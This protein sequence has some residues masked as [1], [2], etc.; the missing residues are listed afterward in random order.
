[1]PLHCLTFIACGA[2]SGFKAVAEQSDDEERIGFGRNVKARVPE[3]IAARVME[4]ELDRTTA[5]ARYGFLPE[6]IG[7][8]NRL[9]AFAPLD[10]ESL[11]AIL[12]DGVLA[13]Y[14]QE[15][16]QEGITLVLE[17]GVLDHL[18]GQALQRETGAR[19]LRA[20]MARSLEDAAY[21]HFGQSGQRTVSLR[22]HGDA[23]VADG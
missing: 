12:V 19:G 9:V 17:E 7:R 23:V 18:V 22:L 6:L 13:Q 15:F 16:A 21:R 20:E 4:E 10:A 11:K 3:A 2:F 5:F 1:M 14:Q 8:F